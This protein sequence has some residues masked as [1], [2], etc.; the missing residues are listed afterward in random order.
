MGEPLKLE[1]YFD[2]IGYA[3]DRAPTLPVLKALHVAHATHIPFENIDVLLN[4]PI[5]LD[6]GHLFRKLVT[7]RRGGYCF[8]QN[9][10]F[11]AVLEEIGFSVT[12]L[13]AR[14]RLGSTR[15]APRTHMLLKV[16]IDRI[17]YLA[18]VGFGGACFLEP[19]ALEAGRAVELFG[20]QHRLEKQGE[21]WVLQS[22]VEGSWMDQYAFTLEE[23]HPADYEVANY[24]VSTFPE[25]HFRHIL[26]AQAQRT[27]V[28]Y[29]L[30]NA[31]LIESRGSSAQESRTVDESEIPGLLTHLFGIRLP[32]GTR[33]PIAPSRHTPA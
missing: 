2:R 17:P 21:S 9:S 19:I 28:R 31:K 22:L 6:L 15:I 7:S 14:V 13:A 29:A 24:Y 1:K 3:G 11:A 32:V 16:D 26:V 23:A 18:D 12:R 10:L 30:H 4:R 27:D 5:S 25:S 8:E 33:I 20:W